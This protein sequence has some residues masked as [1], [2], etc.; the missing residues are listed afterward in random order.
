MQN[1][2]VRTRSKHR[3][4]FTPRRVDDRYRRL[5]TH[6]GLVY[7]VFDEIYGGRKQ[8]KVY[9]AKGILRANC[10]DVELEITTALQSYQNVSIDALYGH[11]YLAPPEVEVGPGGKIRV[12]VCGEYCWSTGHYIQERYQRKYTGRVR[13]YYLA[14]PATKTYS[15]SGLLNFAL[16][17]LHRG[18]VRVQSLCF[19]AI[20]LNCHDAVIGALQEHYFD[21]EW[22]VERSEDEDPSC[23]SS[24]DYEDAEDAR[25]NIMQ[26]IQAAG[27]QHVGGSGP[28]K[29]RQGGRPRNLDDEWAWKEVNE[30]GRP[31]REVYTEWVCRIGERVSSLADPYDSFKKAT[32]RRGRKRDDRG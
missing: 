28:R 23:E 24:R 1:N 29:T 7:K 4:T 16:T 31:P 30:K 5:P 22:V 3:K 26:R 12:L 17:P 14:E 2:F 25:Q 9:N 6:L 20:L 10:S 19:G 8:P 32:K 13:R 11:I 15:V 27:D 18:K 21:A